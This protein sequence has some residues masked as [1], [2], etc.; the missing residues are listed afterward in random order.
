MMQLGSK[1]PQFIWVLVLTLLLT[2][3]PGKPL[4]A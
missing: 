3:E 4:P 1:E 2:M